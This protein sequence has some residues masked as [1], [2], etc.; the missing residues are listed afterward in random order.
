MDDERARA[1]QDMREEAE[2]FTG[3]PG[4]V[5][6]K[7][8]ARGSLLWTVIA[9][10]VGALVG[11]LVGALAFEGE[12]AVITAV[13]GAVAGAADPARATEDLLRALR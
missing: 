3:G 5:A 8:Q 7:S 10:I 12:G 9:T 2:G 13:V 4:V 1:R 11:L 6:S